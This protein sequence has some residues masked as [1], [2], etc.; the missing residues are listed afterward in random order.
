[1]PKFVWLRNALL[2]PMP[3]VIHSDSVFGVRQDKDIGVLQ[4][5]DIEAWEAGLPLDSL[6]LK[7]PYVKVNTDEE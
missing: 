1:M 6:S 2:G 4:K 7:Y 3:S 5:H